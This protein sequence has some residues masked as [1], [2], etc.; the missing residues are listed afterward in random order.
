[1]PPGVAFADAAALPLAHGTSFHALCR[2]RVSAGETVLVLGASG[3]VG[4]AAVQIAKLLGAKVIACASSDEKLR[5]CS[6]HGADQVINYSTHD[7]RDSIRRLTDGKGIDVVIDPVGGAFAEPCVRSMAWNGR[8][9]VVGFAAGE[10]P[11][12]PLNLVLLKGCSIIGAAVGSNAE[13][14]ST[15]YRQNLARLIEW[16]ESGVLKPLVSRTYRFAETPEAI[17][18]MLSRGLV[19]KAV[20]LMDS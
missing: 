13:R 10:I 6:Q 19:G 3:G 7:L 11:R 20:V 1:L 12:I 2:G 4:L 9:V 15:E 16:M 17:E 14:D 18:N 8:Y 5:V